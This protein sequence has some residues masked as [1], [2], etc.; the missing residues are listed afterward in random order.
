MTWQEARKIAERWLDS[1][2]LGSIKGR[3]ID[4]RGKGSDLIVADPAFRAEILQAVIRIL[5]ARGAHSWQL[6]E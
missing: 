4:L 6:P 5:K 1:L 3:H 2:H